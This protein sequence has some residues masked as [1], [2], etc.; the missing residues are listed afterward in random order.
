MDEQERHVN[1]SPSRRR[2]VKAIAAVTGAI[3][4]LPQSW[5]K[6]LV[7]SVVLPAHAQTSPGECVVRTDWIFDD[8][9]C[10]E[11]SNGRLVVFI[12][13]LEEVPVAS[14]SGEVD[15]SASRWEFVDFDVNPSNNRQ[16]AVVL[17]VDSTLPG[18][19]PVM[20]NVTDENG[21]ECSTTFEL[22]DLGPAPD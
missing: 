21:D 20:I 8:G 11:V 2:S 14:A 10:G 18:D 16:F 7:E 15:A 19:T 17:C 4:L 5:R 3:T 12:G 1:S 13:T 9:E 22:D 6:P